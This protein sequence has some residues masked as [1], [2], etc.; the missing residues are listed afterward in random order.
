[1]D[2]PAEQYSTL[3][4]NGFNWTAHKA[5]DGCLLR[6]DPDSQQCCSATQVNQAA[7]QPNNFWR[8]NLTRQYKV[9][10]MDIYARI[11]NT[12]SNNQLAGFHLYITERADGPETEVEVYTPVNHIYAFLF[13]PVQNVTEIIIRRTGTS[14]ITICEVQVFAGMSLL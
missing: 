2:K 12:D 1:M 13:S 3:N 7:Q 11:A 10:K 14:I 5:V 8:V 6:D 9:E 4:Y